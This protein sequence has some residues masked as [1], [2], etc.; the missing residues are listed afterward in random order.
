MINEGGL[1]MP[2]PGM[3]RVSIAPTVFERVPD[4]RRAVLIGVKRAEENC[5]AIERELEAACEHWSACESAVTDLAPV[6]AWRRAFRAVG[7]N[8][9]R[10]R[11]AVEALIRRAQAG[12]LGSLGN[13]AIDAGTLITLEEQVPVGLHVLDQ[14]VDELMLAPASGNERF[15]TFAGEPEPPEPGELVW[16]S[17]E[18]VLTRRWVHKQGSFGSVTATSSCFA[19]NV[20]ALGGD[21][22]A[23][24][25]D[26]TK[27]VLRLAGIVPLDETVLDS[28]HPESVLQTSLR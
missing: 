4:Y 22:L 15:V 3:V 25:V 21:D 27:A 24:A 12:S 20:D 11:P 23:R 5:A 1:T 14:V 2:H 10:T 16:R 13:C 8:P 7:L 28:G 18:Q 6:A 26:R 19:A 17:G 9:T